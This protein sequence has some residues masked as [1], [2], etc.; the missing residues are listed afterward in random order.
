MV[1][2]VRAASDGVAAVLGL[3]EAGEV[4]AGD[5]SLKRLAALCEAVQ[6][7][8]PKEEVAVTEDEQTTISALLDDEDDDASMSLALKRLATGDRRHE[9]G[10]VTPLAPKPRGAKRGC[11]E[12]AFS[13]DEF[14]GQI[15]RMCAVTDAALLRET[16]RTRRQEDENGEEEKE[17]D[18]PPPPRPP[19]ACLGLG[20]LSHLPLE[21]TL[22]VIS[23]L[24]GAE[25]GRLECC[26]RTACGSPG[27]VQ[28][29]ILLVK[30]HQYAVKRL[31]LLKR[32]T[33]PFLV[34][35]WEW[36]RSSRSLTTRTDEV[37][38]ALKALDIVNPYVVPANAGDADAS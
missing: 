14:A 20:S 12:S 1:E 6:A 38:R 23:M 24:N 30:R 21:V 16:K 26:C 19:R 5:P 13:E 10:T 7:L 27:L 4:S 15:D 33:Y 22:A 11:L 8:V 9:D 32:E 18:E 25:L 35:R 34:N 31:P 28:V 36:T 17:D 3:V 29:A 37:A 2:A